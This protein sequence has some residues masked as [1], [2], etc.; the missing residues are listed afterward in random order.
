MKMP[1]L[2]LILT[3]SFN[4]AA[5]KSTTALSSVTV[6]A[7]RSEK[8]KTDVAASIDTKSKD[9]IQMDSPAL[10][11]ELLNSIA[12]V[13]ITQTGS[14][15]GHMTSIRMP[16]STGPYY[17]MLQ[18]GIPVQS[19]GFF[20]HNGL[21]YTNFSTAGSVEVL[22][23]AG[24]ALYGSD[25]VA[26]T[27]NVM[28]KSITEENSLAIKTEVGSDGFLR[29]GGDFSRNINDKSD[30]AGELSHGQS[31][32]WRDHTA[33][34][35]DEITVKHIYDHDDTT[36]F[37]T[38]LTV[39]QSDAEMAGSV[40]GLD[41]LNND[42]TSVGNIQFALDRG[43]DIKRKFDFA[44]LSTEWAH[45]ISN[46]VDMNTILYLRSNRNRYTATWEKNLPHNDSQQKTLGLMFKTNIRR[47]KAG[48]SMGFDA[49][50]TQANTLYTQLF[51]YIPSGYGSAVVK[52]TIYDY[53]V[54]YFA[55]APYLRTEYQL[56]EKLQI[57]AG[58]RYDSNSY[59]YTNNI[60]DG[61][62]AN[63][64]Y[65]RAADN[66]DPTFTHLSPKL[67]VSYKP[68]QDQLIY[69]RYA[70]G[71]RIPQATRLYSLRTNNIDF[72][73]D[74]ETTDTFEV[75]YKLETPRNQVGVSIYHMEI[76]DTITRRENEVGDRFY[77]NSDST[78]HRG[79]EF[80]LESELSDN[81]FSKISYSYS[82]HQYNNDK[83]YSDNEQ[84][85]APSHVGNARITYK[86]KKFSSV[87]VMLEWEHVGS[88]WLDDKN[89]KKY[90]GFDVA[91][92]K[93]SYDPNKKLN[94]FSKLNNITDKIYAETGSIAYGKERYTPAAPRQVFIGL[95]Y[96]W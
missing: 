7:T 18:D 50:Y 81:F 61:Q 12:G 82:K 37:K 34:K 69:G 6:T 54:D 62:Y 73:L 14:T 44:R 74:P 21:A 43:L 83:A 51:D 35:R 53:D 58:I 24:T 90:G 84:A 16:I 8:N 31:D 65:S 36:T 4:A 80:S 92:L 15:I 71:F 10:Q 93:F 2:F 64:S 25:A 78:I 42:A 40:I 63:S 87:E 91:N 23:G 95:E 41:A 39:N 67:D 56:T 3:F 60:G 96:N 29:L 22:K 70:N 88:Y 27:I 38:I 59:D 75:G 19:S 45:D 55:G 77:V 47:G 79:I 46:T 26:A 94:F 30:F 9:E 28:S 72:S 5:E 66:N 49:E 20:N 32:G 17:L 48:F 33:Y 86:S 76:D 11:S 52:G 85:Q 57:G 68:T 13:R 89:T 1:C